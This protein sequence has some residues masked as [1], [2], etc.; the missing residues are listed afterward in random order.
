MGRSVFAEGVIER[1]VPLEAWGWIEQEIRVGRDMTLFDFVHSA[2]RDSHDLR[3][4]MEYI[5]RNLEDGP[6]DKHVID[7]YLKLIDTYTAT[8]GYE[9]EVEVEMAL[10]RLSFEASHLSVPYEQLSGGQKTRAQFA[11]LSVTEPQFLLLDEPTNHLDAATLDWLVVWLKSYG[12]SILFVS[13]DR[14]FIDTV[15]DTTYELTPKGTKRYKGGYSA[16]RAATDLEI[17]T[18]QALYDKQQRERKALLKAS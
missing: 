7:E 16:F 3:R 13:H 14:Y 4:D 12:G 9:Y 6:D 17:R 5:Q 1:G 10:K 15:A 8:G 18:Q 11:E 2:R